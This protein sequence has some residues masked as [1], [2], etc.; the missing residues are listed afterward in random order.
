MTMFATASIHELPAVIMTFSDEMTPEAVIESYVQSI[1]IALSLEGRVYRLF[2]FRQAE[3]TYAQTFTLLHNLAQG[4]AGAIVPPMFDGVVVGAS[5]MADYF[6][7]AAMPFFQSVD[8]ALEH[9]RQS[10]VEPALAS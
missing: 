5:A 1:G 9:C 4:L 10:V 3:L 6:D 2:D 8:D 7:A